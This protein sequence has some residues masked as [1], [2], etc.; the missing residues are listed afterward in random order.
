[1]RYLRNRPAAA[2]PVIELKPTIVV[3]PPPKENRSRWQIAS[4]ILGTVVPTIIAATALF[5]SVLAYQDQRKVNSD[6]IT[7]NSI[8][9]TGAQQQEADKVAF[10]YTYS[11]P[12]KLIVQNLGAAPIYNAV[13]QLKVFLTFGSKKNYTTSWSPVLGTVPPCSRLSIPLS[14]LEPTGILAN[15]ALQENGQISAAQNLGNLTGELSFPVN[16]VFTDANGLTWARNSIGKL[17]RSHP[18]SKPLDVEDQSRYQP[19][20]DTGCT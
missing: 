11:R 19:Q 7:M 3:S 20:V 16:M 18:L 6:Q 14:D 2:Q 17:T 9:A 1:M 8:E 5:L 12:N 4:N 15:L 13:V 10:W